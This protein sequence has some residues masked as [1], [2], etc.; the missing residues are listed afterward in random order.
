[1]ENICPHDNLHI[2]VHHKI[3]QSSQKQPKYPSADEMDK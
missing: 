3:I 1:M 2:Y